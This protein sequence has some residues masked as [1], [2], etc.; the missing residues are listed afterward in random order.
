MPFVLD[1]RKNPDSP[2]RHL[3]QIR[4]S[5]REWW[6]QWLQDQVDEWNKDRKH[7]RIELL[8]IG[9]KDKYE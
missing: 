1:P 8:K 5:H 6:N 3:A 4:D 7:S 2:A 9:L